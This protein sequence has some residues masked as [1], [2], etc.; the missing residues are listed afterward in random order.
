MFCQNYPFCINLQHHGKKQAK[1]A[2]FIKQN[3]SF[4]HCDQNT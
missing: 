3:T 4:G 1:M 2:I